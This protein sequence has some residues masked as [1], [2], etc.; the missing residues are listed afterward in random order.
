MPIGLQELF[1]Q[2]QN[3]AAPR[4]FIQALAAMP[5]YLDIFVVLWLGCLIAAALTSL[6]KD[7]DLKK[8]TT[9]G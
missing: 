4:N 1:F 5:S 7:I 6:P 9:S 2:N 8:T 3:K